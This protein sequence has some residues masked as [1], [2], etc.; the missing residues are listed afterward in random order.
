MDSLD[1]GDGMAGDSDDVRLHEHVEELLTEEER[2]EGGG[3][4]DEHPDLGF[5]LCDTGRPE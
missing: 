2:L 5:Q 3:I 1:N 4:G